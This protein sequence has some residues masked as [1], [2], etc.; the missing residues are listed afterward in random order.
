MKTETVVS[1]RI[2]TACLALITMLSA[3]SPFALAAKTA[4]PF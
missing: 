2:V 1:P 4:T 3:F